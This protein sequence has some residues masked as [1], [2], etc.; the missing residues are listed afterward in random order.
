[1]EVSPSLVVDLNTELDFIYTSNW[2]RVMAS[3]GEWG[4]IMKR[5]PGKGKREIINWLLDTGG[6]YLQNNG[7]NARADDMSAATTEIDIS[8]FGANLELTSNE[9]N[10]NQWAKDPSVSAYDFA[11]KWARDH[12][13]AAAYFPRQQ[14]FSMIL[15]N[16]GVGPNTYD[17]LSFFNANHPT[18]PAYPNGPVYSNIITGVDI[19]AAT[20]SVNDVITAGENLGKALGTIAGLTFNQAAIPRFLVPRII[21][22]PTQLTYRVRQ[23]IGMSGGTAART[24]SARPRTSSS[25]TASRRRSR[26]RS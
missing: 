6:I 26:R 13:A 18:N 24:S 9:L 2:Q 11:K 3:A 15:A 14:L 21:V 8:D 20:G 12:G 1:V 19:S 23:L 10:D 25:N 16:G 7:G 22:P 4:R 17:G 5:R